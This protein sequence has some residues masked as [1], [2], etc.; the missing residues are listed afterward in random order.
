L[1]IRHCWLTELMENRRWS[2]VITGNHKG[3]KQ[4]GV[5]TPSEYCNQKVFSCWSVTF[6]KIRCCWL[7]ELMENW[8]WSSVITDNHTDGKQGEVWASEYCNEKMFSH[9]SVAFLKIRCCWLTELMENRRWS[10]V[11][12]GNHT[13]GKQ[14]GVWT[15]SEYCNQKMC[16]RWSVAF[17][18]ICYSH[19]V[20]LS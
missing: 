12:T 18:K 17:L 2:S 1:K 8:R 5:W 11:I 20:I 19:A 16:S 15:P 7:T 13:D 4:G 6:L 9:W 10:S 14:G 3:G